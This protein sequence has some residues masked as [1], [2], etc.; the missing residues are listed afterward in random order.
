MIR[1]YLYHA[2]EAVAGLIIIFSP[3]GLLYL[4]CGFGYTCH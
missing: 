1:R 2:A 4:A 3:F